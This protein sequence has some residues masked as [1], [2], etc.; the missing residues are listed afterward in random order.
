M[1]ICFGGILAVKVVNHPLIKH[2]IGLLRRDNIG[3]KDFRQLTSEIAMLLTYEATKKFETEKVVI[4]CWSGEI[5]VEKL[6]GKEISIVPI[7]RAGIG[8]LNGVLTILP[9]AK[10]NVVGIFR[11]EETLEPNVYYKKFCSDMPHRK[12]I[13]IDPMLAT[14]NSLCAALNIIKEYKPI[15]IIAICIVAAP[16]GV[17]KICREHEDVEVFV[18]ALDNKLDESG[19]IVPGLGDAGDKIFG[20]K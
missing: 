8:M 17:E 11:N 1:I 19:Y 10:V 13:V 18:G 7:L 15:K 6:E 2:K 20:T 3:T 14:G 16:E 4:R 5:E 9:D 12:V